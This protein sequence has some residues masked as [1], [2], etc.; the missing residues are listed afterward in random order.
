MRAC[1]WEPSSL[2]VFRDAF[3]NVALHRDPPAKGGG[4][5]KKVF[6]LSLDLETPKTASDLQESVSHAFF[7]LPLLFVFLNFVPQD[8]EN[9]N[10]VYIH[11]H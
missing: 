3:V 9:H 1:E 8:C 11:L 5:R 4:G 6:G 10:N 2:P 7:V